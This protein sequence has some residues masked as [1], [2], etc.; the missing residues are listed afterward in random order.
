MSTSLFF[1]EIPKIGGG[2]NPVEYIIFCFHNLQS[3]LIWNT[4]SLPIM[5]VKFGKV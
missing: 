2:S 3:S 4:L 1:I 5:N